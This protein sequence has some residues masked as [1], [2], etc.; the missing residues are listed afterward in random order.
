MKNILDKINRA[1][2]IQA[3]LELNKT[4][5]G[6]H[7]VELGKLDDLNKMLQEMKVS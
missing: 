4:E 6:K 5:L 7:E 1:D 3:N 2:E